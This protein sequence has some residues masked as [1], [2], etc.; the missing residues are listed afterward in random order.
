MPQ[1]TILVIYLV[2]DRIRKL[3][4]QCTG[5]QSFVIF[6][7]FGRGTGSGFTSLIM[8]RLS[9]HQRKKPNL[10][11]AIYPAP[12]IS[13][14]VL[15]T[16][17]NI[18]SMHFSYEHSGGAFSIDN[19]A[20]YNLCRRNLD[21]E[22]PKCTNFNRLIAKIVS[23]ITASLRFDGALRVD[24]TEFQTNIVHFPAST[25]LAPPTYPEC[26]PKRSTTNY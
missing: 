18:L 4:D 1:T 5:V 8:E 2:V 20:I 3:A 7:S 24:L 12:Q 26:R 22:W 15:E 14:V 17:N 6:H 10:E 16:Y 11:F 13:T 23:S 19:E 21:I 25:C 9:V